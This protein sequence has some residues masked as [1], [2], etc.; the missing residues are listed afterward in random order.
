MREL[1]PPG[2]RRPVPPGPGR[3]HGT[4]DNGDFVG[5]HALTLETMEFVLGIGGIEIL[6]GKHG[7][8]VQIII[9][10]ALA[11]RLFRFPI[12]RPVET[13]EAEGKTRGG[14]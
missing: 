6:G 4:A 12:G 2:W 1:W 5:L 11:Q 14:S 8:K 9:A 10:V 13:G 3:Y 7:I